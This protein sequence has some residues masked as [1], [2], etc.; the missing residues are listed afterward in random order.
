M[1][2]NRVILASLV[3]ATL[4]ASALGAARPKFDLRGHRGTIEGIAFHPTE[5]LIASFSVEPEV[6]L[7][8]LETGRQV[9]QMAPS[10]RTVTRGSLRG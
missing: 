6:R 5:Q 1:K 10:G 8:S 9:R 7:W 2:S 3:L 4:C